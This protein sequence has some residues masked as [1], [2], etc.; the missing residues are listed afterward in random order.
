MKTMKRIFYILLVFILLLA[1]C[2]SQEQAIESQSSSGLTGST[3]PSAPDA[4]TEDELRTQIEQLKGSGDYEAV[5]NSAL[6]LIGLAPE[7]TQ[8]YIDAVWALSEMSRAN[9]VEIDRLLAL[10]AEKVPDVR[11][12]TQWAEQNQPDVSIRVP[13]TP[14]YFSSD[15]INIEGITTGNMT[16]AAKYRIDWW[17]GG[18]LTWQGDWV[19]LT[20][21]DED[22]A[23]YKLRSDGSDYQRLGEACGTSLNAVGDWLYYL[24]DQDSR[25]CK[26]RTD[27]SLVT[28]II[29]EEC[30]F[31]SV[32]GDFIYYSGDC[33]YKVRTDGS[34]KTALTEGLTIFPCVSGDWVYYAVKSETGGL[35]KVSVEGGETQQVLN[36]FIQ[37]YC[38]VD[39][40][41]YYVDQNHWNNIYRAHTDGTDA[42]VILPFD[43]RVATINVS[44]GVLYI[45]FNVTNEEQD[46]FIIGSEIVALDIETLEKINSIGAD[47]EPL[48]TGPDGMLYFF[49]YGEGMAWYS[50]DKEGA[51]AKI[52]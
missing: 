31:L 39:D 22:F 27:G 10:G 36:G 37:T 47:T 11:I 30:S 14:D 46:G 3:E 28:I 23:I 29:D 6:E 35:W 26:M 43:F 19:Y 1:S 48:C 15:E 42:E 9:Y 32:S 7:D 52:G 16:N 33:L 24:D 44:D 38:I 51:V 45:S 40:W 50:M 34:E 49:K 41:I 20:R 5:Y 4:P 12:L 18:L 8:A 13:F 2:S 25:P 17:Q 21:P